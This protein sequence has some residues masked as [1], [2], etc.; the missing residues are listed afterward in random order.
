L[1]REDLHRIDALLTGRG[2]SDDV[3]DALLPY[4]QRH[5]ELASALRALPLGEVSNAL[6]L[7][8]GGRK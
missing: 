2:H 7:G 8:A 4:V 3:I 1:E 5:L 6:V